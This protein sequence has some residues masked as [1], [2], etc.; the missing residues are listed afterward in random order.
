MVIITALF[1]KRELN[2]LVRCL[3]LNA[4]FFFI[5]DQG[6]LYLAQWGVDGN[7]CIKDKVQC[8]MAL[9]SLDGECSCDCLWYED[10]KKNLN[11]QYKGQYILKVCLHVCN[12]N[13]PYIL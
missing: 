9:T 6:C 13:S 3:T 5:F 7:E 8:L 12:R 10:A 4:N 1:S 11:H 2:S